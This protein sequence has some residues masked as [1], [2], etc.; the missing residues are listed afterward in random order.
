M[1]SR[2]QAIELA[3][4]EATRLG[5]DVTNMQITVSRHSEPWN[6]YFPKESR[7]MYCKERKKYL[8]EKEYWAVYY[9]SRKKGGDCCIF[10]DVATG[11]ILT[12]YRGK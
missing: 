11:K 10:V 4:K 1:L 6:E 8:E 12:T 9:G 2:D 7:S 3:G 5:Y